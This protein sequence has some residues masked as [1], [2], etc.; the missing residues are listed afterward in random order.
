MRACHSA[1]WLSGYQNPPHGGRTGNR[2]LNAKF[3]RVVVLHFVNLYPQGGP[4][5][6]HGRGLRRGISNQP[7]L[8]ACA[9]GVAGGDAL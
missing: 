2:R 7:A 8:V 6:Y 1:H 9:S 4:R 5:A 3:D